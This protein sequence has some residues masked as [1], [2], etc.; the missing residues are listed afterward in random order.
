[1]SKL[2]IFVLAAP[3]LA[4]TVRYGGVTTQGGA[5]DFSAAASTKPAKSGTTLPSSCSVG[6]LFFK[7][8]AAP[9]SAVLYACT[10]ANTWTQ[11]TGGAGTAYSQVQDEGTNLTP[12]NTLNFTGG[13]VAC[14]DDSANSRTNCNVPN[15]A[16]GDLSGTL[17]SATVTA[18]QGRA[19]ASTAPS[20]GQV[21]KWNNAASQWQP[22][23]DNDTTSVGGDLSGSQTAAT[24]IRLQGRSVAST[25]PSNGQVLTWNQTASQWEPQ[26]PSGGGGGSGFDILDPS[27][28][29]FKEEFWGGL[30]SAE[31]AGFVSTAKGGGTCSLGGMG[32][33]TGRFGIRQISLG[34]TVAAGHECVLYASSSGQGTGGGQ[35]AV[36]LGSNMPAGHSWH[37]RWIVRA[38]TAAADTAAW[39]GLTWLDASPFNHPNNPGIVVRF[40]P[41]GTTCSSGADSTTNWVLQT[42]TSS[43]ARHCVDT[44]VAYS[45]TAWMNIE[46]FSTTSGTVQARI[47]GSTPVSSSTNVTNNSVTFAAGV[48]AVGTTAPTFWQDFW[49]FKYTG[50]QR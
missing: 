46:I 34:G 21:L 18:L 12:R 25:A 13:G 32:P 41:R 23:A 14:S 40:D 7:T 45:P 19:V 22:G 9:T 17:P 16:G 33:V 26:T 8:D 27:V 39:V 28:M 3:L 24:V 31:N 43:G 44:G 10:A 36:D 6:E 42:Y 48:M 50:A 2:T 37:A 38:A 30:N 49:S 20:D 15:T 35:F 4:Q 11:Q 47:N 29:W 1:M 5:Q